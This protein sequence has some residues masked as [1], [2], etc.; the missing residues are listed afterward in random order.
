MRIKFLLSLIFVCLVSAA[1]SAQTTNYK[2]HAIFVFSIAKYS[3]WPA[4]GAGNQFV[5]A[6]LGKTKLYDEL[7]TSSANHTIN[8][9]KVSVLLV[10]DV[11]EIK[12][13]QMVLV[14]DSKSSV[15]PDLLKATANQPVMIVTEREGL[16]KK[17]AGVSFFVNDAGKLNFDLNL[18]EMNKRTITLSKNLTS[19]AASTL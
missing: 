10:D 6:V 14:S 17:G 12:Q 16:H 19:L 15:L 7:V 2:A 18:T 4:A 9:M 13:P 1:T 8:G 5:I 3:Q 11:S